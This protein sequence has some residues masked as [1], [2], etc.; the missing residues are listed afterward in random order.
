MNYGI[1][2][3]DMLVVLHYSSVYLF[4][5]AFLLLDPR[6]SYNGL[7]EDYVDDADLLAGL[8]KSKAV[9]EAH[10]KAHYSNSSQQMS[11]PESQ[12]DDLPSGSPV[13]F[14]VFKRYGGPT[15][16]TTISKN[17]LEDYFR[18]T[19]IP[20]PFEDTDPLKW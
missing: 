3:G 19:S 10:F 8:D 18:L 4:L 14:D 12:V 16:S 6:L 15:I 1:I 9:L 5:I 17:K 2:V 11:V 20:G 13:K 7:R